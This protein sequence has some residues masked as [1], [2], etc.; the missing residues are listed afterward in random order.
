MLRASSFALWGPLGCYLLWAAGFAFRLLWGLAPLVYAEEVGSGGAIKGL[1][2][3][4]RHL[5]K[6]S[7]LA[8]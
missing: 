8:R 1:Q 3:S 5:R 2:S 7:A 6:V 4:V